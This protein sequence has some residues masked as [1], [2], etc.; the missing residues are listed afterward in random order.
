MTGGSGAPTLLCVDDDPDFLKTLKEYFAHHGFNVLTASDGEEAV[1]QATRRMPDAVIL[2]VFM[3]GLGG[4]GTLERIR[5]RAPKIVAILV[6]GVSNAL[7][8]LEQ[9]G[10]GVTATFVKP[11]NLGDLL[12]AVARAGVAPPEAGP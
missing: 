10:V 8:I 5:R 3:P 1:S 4:L 2:D 9:A 7:E 6:S 11:V 12:V